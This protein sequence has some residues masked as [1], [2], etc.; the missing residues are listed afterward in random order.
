MFN[1]AE[2][3][4]QFS[5]ASLLRKVVEKRE[6]LWLIRFVA[7]FGYIVISSPDSRDRCTDHRLLRRIS[8]LVQ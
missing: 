2:G 1:L 4:E 6:E 3:L 7:H 8:S 5:E